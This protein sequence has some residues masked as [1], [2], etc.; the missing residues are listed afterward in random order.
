M[1]ALSGVFAFEGDWESNLADK[2][3]VRPLLETIHRSEGVKFIHRRIGTEEELDHYL[4]KWLQK[5]YSQYRIGQFAFHGTPGCLWIGK[6]EIT[7]ESLGD[8]ING[9]AGG[10]I[11][12]FDSCSTVRLGNKRI[13]VF[14]AKT[15]ADAVIGF[16]KDVGWIASAAFELL[17][18]QAFCERSTARGV[19][20]WLDSNCPGL[21]QGLGMKFFSN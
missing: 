15:G 8:K 9:R 21:V 1:S 13:E 2:K 11:I 17:V 6:T 7:I 4:K 3:S 14:L 19:K 10:R 20:N 18:L 12:Y 5:G 16:T